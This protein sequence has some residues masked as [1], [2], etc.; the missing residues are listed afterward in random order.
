MYQRQPLDF[1]AGSIGGRQAAH[2]AIWLDIMSTAMR[3][4]LLAYAA[5]ISEMI[6]QF[7]IEPFLLVASDSVCGWL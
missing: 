4:I 7:T 5:G 1:D 3:N 6:F 2:S